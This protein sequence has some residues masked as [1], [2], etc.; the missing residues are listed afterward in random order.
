M[1]GETAPSQ[2]AA[3]AIVRV[4]RD[5]EGVALSFSQERL[6]FLAELEP[7]SAAYNL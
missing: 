2:P 1:I 3:P 5:R 4:P 6:W 7:E